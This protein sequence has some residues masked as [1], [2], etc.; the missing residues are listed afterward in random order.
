MSPV[1]RR[2]ETTQ[3]ASNLLRLIRGVA[4]FYLVEEA[5]SL[6]VIDARTSA[7][8][9]RLSRL[10]AA[11][12]R[13]IKDIEA[14]LLTHAHEDHIGFAERA[15]VESGAT[16]L[17]QREDA[18]VAMGQK[19]RKDSATLFRSD[20]ARRHRAALSSERQ[21]KGRMD[22][23]VELSTYGHGEVLDIPG[24]PRAVHVPG[25]TPGNAVVL[26][27]D[28]RILLSGD[29]IVTRNPLTG[30]IGPQIMPSAFNRDTAQALRS[31]SALEGLHADFLLPGH[32]KPWT[33]GVLSAVRWARALAAS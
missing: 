9:D 18:A 6:T 33:D 16:V 21:G 14:V 1:R 23:D 26:L 27:E 32:G 30:R 12:G 17:I 15:R 19:R 20:R 28:R 24:H 8:W 25:H 4:N 7:D 22:H 2:Q 5:G 29:T 31:L 3:V 13:H 11:E 10:L